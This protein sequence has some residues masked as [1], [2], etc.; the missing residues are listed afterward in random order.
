M[1]KN[2]DEVIPASHLK[3]LQRIKVCGIYPDSEDDR[4]TVLT[5]GIT[6]RQKHI[7]M[8][9]RNPRV[10]NRENPNYI[11]MRIKNVP[12]STDDGH[13][14]RFLQ[15]GRVNVHSYHRSSD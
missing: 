14:F 7:T 9:S 3:G 1:Y 6:V 15:T 2:I 11:E 10:T 5:T 13:I 12:L 4:D 8:Y